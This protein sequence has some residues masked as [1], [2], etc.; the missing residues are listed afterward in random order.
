M[1]SEKFVLARRP[2]L[3]A[4]NKIKLGNS[5]ETLF[6]N[7]Y[8]R[9]WEC[10][11]VDEC[12]SFSATNL[13]KIIAAYLSLK[14]ACKSL[15]RFHETRSDSFRRYRAYLGHWIKHCIVFHLYDE[16]VRCWCSIKKQYLIARMKLFLQVI[17]LRTIFT[18][19]ARS[20]DDRSTFDFAYLCAKYRFTGEYIQT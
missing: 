9:K 2:K 4:L 17:Q 15:G 6:P 8:G 11:F 12:V 20:V 16:N 5:E 7:S 18:H 14:L 19:D 3:A 1:C 10:H 13:I